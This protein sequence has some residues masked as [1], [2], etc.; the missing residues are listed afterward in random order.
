MRFPFF[1]WSIL[2]AV[3]C[4]TIPSA[5]A[6]AVVVS[7]S[8][9]WAAAT[10]TTAESVAGESF[11]FSFDIS[12]PFTGT[13]STGS[14]ATTDA[15]NF[16]YDLNGSPVAVS[17]SA[18]VFYAPSS[19]GLFDLELSDGDLLD[20]FGPDIGSTGTLTF[21]DTSANFAIND[22]FSSPIGSGNGSV[23]VSST[24]PEP[25]S[26]TLLGTGLFGLLAVRRNAKMR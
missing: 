12:N 3:S 17:L 14:L 24:V 18:V 16:S 7:G 15:M 5:R 19:S 20:A 26:F 21:T 8:G 11:S 6:D 22:P 10:P 9:T 1:G 25:I 23:S 4:L 13:A 2:A